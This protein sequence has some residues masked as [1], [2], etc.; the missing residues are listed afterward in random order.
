MHKKNHRKTPKH[1]L[2]EQLKYL[3]KLLLCLSDQEVQE[4][5]QKAKHQ[6]QQVEETKSELQQQKVDKKVTKKG[7]QVKTNPRTKEKIQKQ[8]KNK[9]GRHNENMKDADETRGA[10]AYWETDAEEV[11]KS[12]GE[13]TDLNT[14]EKANNQQV[15]HKGCEGTKRQE[16]T[17][18][19]TQEQKK[20][21]KVRGI[22]RTETLRY[23]IGIVIL[24]FGIKLS[25][26]LRPT[27]REEK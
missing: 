15:N 8:P 23:D 4:K 18:T 26:T 21:Y 2:F 3:L 9:P 19:I 14:P 20:K 12:N 25:P 10:N 11:I 24:Q 16:V 7:E 6:D 27:R 17:R 22:D 5:T 13:N 1:S